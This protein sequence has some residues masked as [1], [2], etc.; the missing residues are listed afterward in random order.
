M[1]ILSQK[2]SV[3]N[4]EY[5]GDLEVMKVLKFQERVNVVLL[6]ARIYGGVHLGK[7][8]FRLIKEVA[9]EALTQVPG[10]I[11]CLPKPQ[12]TEKKRKTQRMRKGF[13][14]ERRW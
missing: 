7:M 12:C 8:C 9:E 2:G 5:F 14:G 6:V 13:K 1:K 4:G 3:S 11:F 10:Q